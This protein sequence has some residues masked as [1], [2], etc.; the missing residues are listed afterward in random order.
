[1]IDSKDPYEEILFIKVALDKYYVNKKSFI[2]DLKLVGITILSLF[3]PKQM[4]HYLLLN[5]LS[6]DD[7]GEFGLREIAGKAKLKNNIQNKIDM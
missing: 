6:I 3:L 1:L 2:E 5:L 4:G 7:K